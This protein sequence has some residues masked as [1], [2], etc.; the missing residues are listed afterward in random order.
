MLRLMC[1]QPPACVADRHALRVAEATGL[2]ARVSPS[3]CLGDL[4]A[5]EELGGKKRRPWPAL[6][7]ESLPG[8]Q[9]CIARNPSEPSLGPARGV[10]PLD[11][12]CGPAEAA[13]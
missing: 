5:N 6:A 9:T 11:R 7:P 8:G 1:G 4:A 13:G 3:R 12:Q 10:P 2:E